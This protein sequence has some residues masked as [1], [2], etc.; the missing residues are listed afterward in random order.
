M[1]NSYVLYKK[2]MKIRDTNI[3]RHYE[4]RYTLYI[5]WLDCKHRISETISVTRSLASSLIMSD[6]P[7]E[8]RIKKAAF[9]K[10]RRTQVSDT[11]LYPEDG[12]LRRRLEAADHWPLYNVLKDPICQIHFFV[13]GKKYRKHTIYCGKCGVTLCLLYYKKIHSISYL[14]D[15]K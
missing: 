15:V 3:M 6:G 12:K 11:I 9:Q 14:V 5:S 7:V 10:R 8:T 2:Y 13:N 1:R 4:F